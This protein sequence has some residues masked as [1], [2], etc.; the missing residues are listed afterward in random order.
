ME[1][2]TADALEAR[3]ERL[4][5]ARLVHV[6][7]DAA[8][9][10]EQL[11]PHDVRVVRER[12]SHLVFAQGEG[13]LDNLLQAS[14]LLPN[15]LAAMIAQKVFPPVITA[16][17]SGKLDGDR[18]S[19]LIRHVDTGYLADM[20]PHLDPANIADVVQALPND[21][22]VEVEQEINRR[23]DHV[24]AGHLVGVAP[25]RVIPDFLAAIPD[26]RDL[27]EIAFFLEAKDR[28][29]AIVAH[30]DD[31]RVARLLLAAEREGLW[32][33][34]LRLVHW[35]RDGDLPKVAGAPLLQRRAVVLAIV[36]AAAEVDEWGTVARV[37][38]AM[39]EDGRTAVLGHASAVDAAH[40][41][42]L[43]DAAERLGLEEVV[44]G[45]G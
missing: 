34:L 10:L 37:A 45:L 7:D 20:A 27:L 29:D 40:V 42:A 24:S 30:V 36:E 13:A 23:G 11:P 5:K 22:M 35:M 28:L 4:K 21:V 31:E 9:F 25:D 32:P 6:D 16:L 17:V 15:A 43:R 41:A 19:A 18:A 1:R 3:A 2:G 12:L 39:D 33:T 8:G 44:A 38:A 26:E 14:R